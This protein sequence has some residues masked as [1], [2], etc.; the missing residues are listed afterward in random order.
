[1]ADVFATP[2]IAIEKHS[3]GSMLLTSKEPLGAPAPQLA[4][5]LRRWAADTPDAVL[6][7]ERS[8]TSGTGWRTLTYQQARHG[9]DALG[10]AL[11]AQGLGPTGRWWCFPRIRSRTCC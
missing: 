9:A 11:L 2:R 6:A 5:L 4:A 1:M 3:D 7:A 10:E 8:D